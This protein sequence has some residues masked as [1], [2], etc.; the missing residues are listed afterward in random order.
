[1]EPLAVGLVLFV[2]GGRITS[3]ATELLD[4]WAERVVRRGRLL[5]RGPTDQLVDRRLQRRG[6]SDRLR[7]DIEVRQLLARP[8]P[9]VDELTWPPALEADVVAVGRPR[10]TEELEVRQLCR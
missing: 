7:P 4:E 1:R 3:G 6:D 8:P 10:A 5:P 9:A 2:R